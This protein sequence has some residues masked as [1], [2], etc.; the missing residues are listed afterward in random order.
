MREQWLDEA[1]EKEEAGVYVIEFSYVRTPTADLAVAFLV[2]AGVAL[3]IL[4]LRLGLGLAGA[5][6]ASIPFLAIAATLTIRVRGWRLID[7][8]VFLGVTFLRMSK[9][10]MPYAG[11]ITA[12][13]VTV[14]IL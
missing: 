1:R 11:M 9:G 8:L 13:G 5:A 3:G 10:D 12:D 14:R 7:H 6:L 4:A 2:L